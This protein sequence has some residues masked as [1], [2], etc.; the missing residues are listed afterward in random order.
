[1]KKLILLI[2]WIF[3]I[4]L[5]LITWDGLIQDTIPEWNNYWVIYGSKVNLDGAPSD[6]LKARLDVGSDLY[7]SWVIQKIIVSW[8]IWIE[9]YDEAEVMK[10]YL[11]ERWIDEWGVLVDSDGYTTR[12]T[13]ENIWNILWDQENVSVVWVSQFFHIS[14][15]KLSLEQA[16]FKNVY[17]YAS[18]YFE[19]RD[20]YSL[21]REFPAYIK[22]ALS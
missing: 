1:M 19:M 9:W 3:L 22:Y 7:V 18:R 21:L 6:R 12:K 5:I 13:S 14:R 15:V 17:W 8:W 20:L 2:I 11:L 4:P 10:Q 16:W